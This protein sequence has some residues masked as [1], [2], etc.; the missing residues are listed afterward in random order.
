MTTII[1]SFYPK[2]YIQSS[3]ICHHTYLGF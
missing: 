2:I 3:G 1:L